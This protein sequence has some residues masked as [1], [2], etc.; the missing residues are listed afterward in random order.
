MASSCSTSDGCSY[1][2]SDRPTGTYT[3]SVSATNSMWESGPDTELTVVVAGSAPGTVTNL[4]AAANDGINSATV[5][6]EA[7][8]DEN[9]G[10]DSSIT[11]YTVVRDGAQTDSMLPS[12]CA[13][14]GTPVI[15]SKTFG[16]LAYGYHSFSVTAVNTAGSGAPSW[17]DVDVVD[18]N[19]TVGEVP[20]QVRRLR[21][22][23]ASDSQD[24]TVKWRVPQSWGAVD[25]SVT[26]YTVVR[27]NTWT[28]TLEA[29]ACT[30]SGLQTSCSV[31]YTNL[32][33]GRQ[34]FSVAAV[35][36]TGTG[37]AQRVSR[38]VRARE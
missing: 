1:S 19:A 3:Y 12:S 35:N 20:T 27:E 34:R 29:S 33:T 9:G 18:P 15:C 24:V 36:E 37:P 22:R 32:P 28:S 13:Q 7:P 38:R 4:T 25:P 16:S 6:W 11:S 21:A 14:T 8:L 30:G 2:E 17:V 5:S 26:S 31:T 23:Q 10:T